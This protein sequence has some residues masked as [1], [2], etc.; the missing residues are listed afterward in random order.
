MKMPE[1]Y[2]AVMRW[3]I[4]AIRRRDDYSLGKVGDSHAYVLVAYHQAPVVIK[5]VLW[6]SPR[7]WE[8]TVLPVMNS[9]VRGLAESYPQSRHEIYFAPTLDEEMLRVRKMHMMMAAIE[10]ATTH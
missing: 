3:R 5:E 9:F 7:S 2:P 1:K 8:E 4:S 10:T 6:E